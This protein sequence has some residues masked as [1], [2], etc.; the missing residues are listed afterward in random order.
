MHGL[1]LG[2]ELVELLKEQQLECITTFASN[3]AETFFAAHGFQTQLEY[4][5]KINHNG[6]KTY[7]DSK[8]MIYDPTA[9]RSSEE[10]KT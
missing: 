5:V 4:P 2:S 7:D 9:C 1:G 10:S 8:L 6:D 3:Q